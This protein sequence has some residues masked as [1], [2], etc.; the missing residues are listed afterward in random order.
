MSKTFFTDASGNNKQQ[1]SFFEDAQPIGSS[2]SKENRLLARIKKWRPIGEYG[3]YHPPIV[4]NQSLKR[5]VFNIFLAFWTGCIDFRSRSRALDFWLPALLYF[6]CLFADTNRSPKWVEMTAYYVFIFCTLPMFACTVRRLRDVQAPPYLAFILFFPDV[7]WV[8]GIFC[9]LPTDG[10]PAIV[11]KFIGE[12]SY[13]NEDS[14]AGGE[15]VAGTS[16]GFDGQIRFGGSLDSCFAPSSVPAFS[17]LMT[18]V[19]WDG[20]N[21]MQENAGPEDGLPAP[22]MGVVVRAMPHTPDAPDAPVLVLVLPQDA[23][24]NRLPP[25]EACLRCL[26]DKEMD[27]VLRQWDGRSRQFNVWLQQA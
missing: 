11:K 9:L 21:G 18:T 20:A 24:K 5:R 4:Q 27:A 7:L 19:I 25:A 15:P 13:A 8:L 26:S 17:T 10:L 14:E 3:A 1:P 2:E 12:A 6:S 23:R 22:V 16:N